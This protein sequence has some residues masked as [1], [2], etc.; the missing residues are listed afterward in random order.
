M[1][2]PG[3]DPGPDRRD[4][5]DDSNRFTQAQKERRWAARH[6][7]GVDPRPRRRR[8]VAGGDQ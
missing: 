7:T 2:A 3:P 1:T 8:T 6:Q 4:L 5:L